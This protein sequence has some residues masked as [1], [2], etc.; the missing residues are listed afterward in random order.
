VQDTP[1][2]RRE[3][4]HDP[5]HVTTTSTTTEPAASVA[6]E[7]VVAVIQA[8]LDED[9]AASETSEGVL[10]AYQVHCLDFGS[11]NVG[12]VFACAGS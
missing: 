12:D 3:T 6:I 2:Q 7:D 5:L 11:V 9:F 10:G 4:R 8:K 1:G